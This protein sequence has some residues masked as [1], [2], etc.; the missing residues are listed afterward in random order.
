MT[1]GV[2]T[3]LPSR[4][5]KAAA[6]TPIE[7]TPGAV[8]PECGSAL[9]AAPEA[10]SSSSS[11]GIALLGGLGAI[12]VAAILVLYVAF[13][14]K[15]A[16]AGGYYM[17][18]AGSNTIGS[19]LG[20]ALVVAWLQSKGATDVNTTARADQPEKVV[21]ATLNGAPVKVEI[22]AHGS[23]TAFTS[24]DA[25]TADVGMA[26]RSIKPEEVT[27]L[28]RFGDFKAA[29]NEHVLGLDGVAVVVP[30]SNPIQNASLDQLQGLFDGKIT[31]WSAIGG[32]NLPVHIY[33]RDDKSGTYD[34]FKNLVLRGQKLTTAKRFEDS[35]TLEQSVANDPGGIG[36][37]GLPYVK[38]T[39][40]LAVSDGP[41]APLLPTVF[42]VKT[43]SYPLS[44]RLFLYTATTPANSNVLDFVHFALSP[45]GQ[46][47]VRN[48]QFVDLELAGG[49]TKT[50]AAS[51]GACTLSSSFPGDRNAYC[52]LRSGSEQL[53][54]TF[55]FRTASTQLDTRAVAD[56][57]RVVAR[58]KQTP[59]KTLVLAGFADS[60]GAYASNCALA[61]S[62]ARAVADAFSTEG[63]KADVQGFCSELPVRANSSAAGREL[64]RR[65]E[66]YLR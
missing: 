62:R 18:L 57:Q 44:R 31:N 36:F 65:V 55:R 2:C 30:T 20:P 43:E 8:C 3:N 16:G 6:K 11:F 22:K 1:T 58:M 4:C 12:A 34:T 41:A 49:T 15:P 32:P 45:A 66:L 59:E 63:I 28:A 64:N 42:S 50:A 13:T 21:S 48:Q 56:L 26:S 60:N 27:K 25:G 51:S 10:K 23:E 53:G 61:N 5:S 17:R 38:T 19:Q 47:I 46:I 9:Q 35:A 33:A 24:L 52:N 14:H 40:A 7:M 29:S 54:T 39:R 37:I